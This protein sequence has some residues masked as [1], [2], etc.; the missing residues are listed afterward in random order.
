[1]SHTTLPRS[2][3]TLVLAAPLVAACGSDVDEEGWPVAGGGAIVDTG[4]SFCFDTT[5]AIDCPASGAALFGQDAQHSTLAPA[6]EDRDDGTALDL[7]TGLV[8]TK[9]FTQTTWSD[10]PAVAASLTT[11]GYDDWRVPTIDE[12]YS[13]MSFAGNTGS[14]AQ[15]E[16]TVPDDAVPFVDTAHFDFEYGQ[17]GRFIDAQYVTSTV[18]ASTVM[19]GQQAFFGVNFADGRIKGYPTERQGLSYYAYF[20]R[21]AGAYGDGEYVDHGDD[22]VT[23]QSTG[24]M[25]MKNDNGHYGVGDGTY[26][27]LNWQQALAY[28]VDL[29]LAGYDDWRLPDAKELQ[30]IVDYARSPET[31]GSA[32]ID[33][34]FETTAITV[35]D[36]SQNFP[37]YWSSTT[38]VEG[39]GS[40][41]AYVAF[42][43]AFG[44]MTG[45][46]GGEPTFM[47][48]HGAGCQRSDP[49]EGDPSQY[50]TGFGPQGDVIRIY[51]FVRCVRLGAE[52]TS[53][54][55]P[56]SAWNGT[57]TPPGPTPCTGDP[58]CEAPDACPPD[59]SLGCTCEQVADGSYC[60]PACTAD[61]DC[62]PGMNGEVLRCA[63]GSCVPGG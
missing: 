23:D 27:G 20:V 13:L 26:G 16:L 46:S 40:K 44:F 29:E 8:W 7:N 42:G 19:D 54:T 49:K 55:S 59:A 4:Q 45:P 17:E 24:L 57:T 60:V 28:C 62:P 25:W 53:D 9:Q 41:A 30:S 18:Y 12:L 6:Y 22:T 21:G 34:V 10:A 35:E 52:V 43:Q 2:L 36:G 15:D 3:L 39:D 1:M 51:N 38:H 32:A 14:G 11:G 58:D 5:T 61:A 37:F 56:A 63:G 33:P 50:P 31:T 47:D 48:V